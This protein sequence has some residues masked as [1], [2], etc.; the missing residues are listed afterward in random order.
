MRELS[1]LVM[2]EDMMD[3]GSVGLSL[4]RAVGLLVNEE[5]WI[6]ERMEVC[7]SR[8]MDVGRRKEAIARKKA[9]GYL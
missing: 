8:L 1:D 6:D 3:V 4:R 2:L 7:S 9:K 5:L